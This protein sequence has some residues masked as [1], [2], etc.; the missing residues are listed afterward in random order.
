M[1]V[2]YFFRKM[3]EFFMQ[4]GSLSDNLHKLAKP[5]YLVKYAEFAQR[6]E[7]VTNTLFQRNKKGHFYS[8]EY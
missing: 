3:G 4:I 2:F 5:F 1:T 6:V 8:N 7:K